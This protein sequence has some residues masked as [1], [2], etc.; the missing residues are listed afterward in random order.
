MSH[1]FP[2]EEEKTKPVPGVLFSRE[3]GLYFGGKSSVTSQEKHYPTGII[4]SFLLSL[5]Q[6]LFLSRR[7]GISQ[8][9]SQRWIYTIDSIAKAEFENHAILRRE[10]A[11]KVLIVSNR[12]KLRRVT[13]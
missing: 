6:V 1:E 4:V 8:P 2:V 10:T 12:R 9:C 5:G 3:V 11:V 7:F 13:H